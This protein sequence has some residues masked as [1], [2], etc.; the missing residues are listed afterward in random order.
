MNDADDSQ[1]KRQPTIV[2][3]ADRAGVAIGTVSRYLNGQPVRAGNRN[4]IAQAITDLGYRRNALAAAMTVFSTVVSGKMGLKQEDVLQEWKT[5]LI[6]GIQM[7]PSGVWALGRA[8]EHKCA[9][10]FAG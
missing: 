6:P 5:N 4:Q 2:E 8:Q 3:V 10:I 9:Y 7:V 1:G